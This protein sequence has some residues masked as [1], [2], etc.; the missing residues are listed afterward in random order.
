VIDF[1]TPQRG[2]IPQVAH[3]LLVAAKNRPSRLRAT[4]FVVYNYSGALKML[5]YSAPYLLRFAVRRNNL[6]FRANLAEICVVREEIAISG[7]QLW[8]KF[9]T[10][11][12]EP[13]R[14]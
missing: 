7:S 3:S 14:K 5:C 4:P 6:K 2:E 8:K 1:T 9:D 11:N 12:V 13:K 10:G